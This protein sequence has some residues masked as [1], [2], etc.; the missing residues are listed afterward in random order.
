MEICQKT[1]IVVKTPHQKNIDPEIIPDDFKTKN[2]N[3]LGSWL[4]LPSSEYYQNPSAT[5]VWGSLLSNINLLA[6]RPSC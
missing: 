4:F 1:A 3:T 6:D 5:L 2:L